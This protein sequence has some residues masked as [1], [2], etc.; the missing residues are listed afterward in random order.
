MRINSF[1]EFINEKVKLTTD[2]F[3]EKAKK[4]H[5]NKYDYS[6]INYINSATPVEIICQKHGIFKQTPN[7]HLS[8]RGCLLCGKTSTAKKLK[9]DTDCFIEKSIKVH[10]G[11]YDYSRV[12]YINIATPVEIICQKHGIFK[13]A[14]SSHYKGSG[15]PKCSYEKKMLNNDEFI[16]MA[17][18]THGD[19]YDY[20]NVNYDG[21]FKPIEIICTKHGIFKQTP[22]R[23]LAGSGCKKCSIDRKKSNTSEF[24]KKARIIHND[25]YDYSKSE[26]TGVHDRINII[27]KKHGIFQQSVEGHLKGRGCPMCK[28]SKGELN[29]AISL[30]NLGI[31]FI[32]NKKFDDCIGVYGLKLPFDFYLPDHNMCIEYDGIQHFRISDFYGGNEAFIR[33][34]RNDKIKT[35]YCEN[36]GITLLR[37]PYKISGYTKIF[38]YLEDYFELNFEV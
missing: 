15:C 37:I 30:K 26:Y 4:I 1:Y 25:K 17:R 27:C 21:S 7:G 20:S 11:K 16:K 33:Q 35:D 29:T 6:R 32:R 5:D 2:E 18:L 38:N 8:G 14:P 13:Q 3:I 34:Q 36:N 22:T 23:H 28:E 24:I 19:K 12:N 10:G 9:K 31:E